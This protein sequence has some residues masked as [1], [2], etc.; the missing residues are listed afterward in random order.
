LWAIACLSVEEGL[1]VII[2]R[3]R[4]KL[5]GSAKHG[6]ALELHVLIDDFGQKRRLDAL[7]GLPRSIVQGPQTA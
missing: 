5:R 1:L 6:G 3:K 7:S 2:A 4:N